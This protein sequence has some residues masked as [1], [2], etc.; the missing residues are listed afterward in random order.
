[1]LYT[2]REAVIHRMMLRIGTGERCASS[3]KSTLF[4]Y[5]SAIFH[6]VLFNFPIVFFFFFSFF[7]VRCPSLSLIDLISRSTFSWIARLM[8]CASA[9]D[10]VMLRACVSC[11]RTVFQSPHGSPARVSTA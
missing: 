6:L 11:L 7:C 10:S 3:T 2:Y 8:C 9:S 5:A 4:R 1:M